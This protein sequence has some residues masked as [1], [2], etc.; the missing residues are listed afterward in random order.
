[1]QGQ[2]QDSESRS[3]SSFPKEMTDVPSPLRFASP[4]RASEVT[5]AV[6]L[7]LLA[8]APTSAFAQAPELLYACY[9]PKT[10]TVYRI[11]SAG[12]PATCVK[13]EHV[14]FSWNKEGPQGPEGPQGQLALPAHRGRWGRGS[15]PVRCWGLRGPVRSRKEGRRQEGR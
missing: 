15:V 12:A 14:E 11:R 10:G 2:P 8:S 9:V 1:M 5:S 7:L 4:D 6:G 3:H 13:A